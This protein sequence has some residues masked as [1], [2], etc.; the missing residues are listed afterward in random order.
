MNF[1]AAILFLGKFFLHVFEVHTLYG[2]CVFKFEKDAKDRAEP[3]TQR[4]PREIQ[5]YLLTWAMN[6]Q[7]NEKYILT[8]CEEFS[9]YCQVLERKT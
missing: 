9:P 8:L 7:E 4:A 5:L 6:F 1:D 3:A 2:V